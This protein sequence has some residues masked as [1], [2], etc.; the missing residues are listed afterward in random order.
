MGRERQDIYYFQFITVL[1]L[2]N[3]CVA[4]RRKEENEVEV[5]KLFI[6]EIEP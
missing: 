5:F 2:E 1:P 6:L 3:D 4:A